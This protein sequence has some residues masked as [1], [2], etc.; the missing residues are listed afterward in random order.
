MPIYGRAWA[1]P[2]LLL[3]IFGDEPTRCS[4]CTRAAAR[5]PSWQAWSPGWTEE[6][7]AT[8]LKATLRVRIYETT[9][10]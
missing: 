10:M 7:W 4:T 6:P 5:V 2:H 3:A 1:C 8:R 9:I